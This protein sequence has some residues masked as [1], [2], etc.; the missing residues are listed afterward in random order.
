LIL[1]FIYRN[2]FPEKWQS[3]NTRYQPQNEE[4]NYF[5]PKEK[6]ENRGFTNYPGIAIHISLGKVNNFIF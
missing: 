6:S 1:T 3:Q 2:I 5:Y 4:F